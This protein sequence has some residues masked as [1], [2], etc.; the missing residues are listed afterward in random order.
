MQRSSSCFPSS[1]CT[2]SACSIFFFSVLFSVL[3]CSVLFSVLSYSVLSSVLFYVLSCPDLSSFVPLCIPLPYS[4][5]F[6]SVL[7]SSAVIST[8]L[9]SF[10]LISS[11]L[12]FTHSLLL[13]PILFCINLIYSVHSHSSFAH[14]IV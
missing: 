10:L 14:N 3:P 4:V 6:F 5:F 2:L 7:S 9:F 1:G 12:F 8:T 11:A 13:C